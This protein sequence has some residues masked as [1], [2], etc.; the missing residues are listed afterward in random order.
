M[1]TG[2]SITS[3]IADAKAS[4]NG[5]LIAL[6]MNDGQVRAAEKAV[7]RGLM[8]K[9]TVMWPGYGAVASYSIAR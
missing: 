9:H 6:A 1:T 2:H 3:I 5:R 4:N 8:T 7:A